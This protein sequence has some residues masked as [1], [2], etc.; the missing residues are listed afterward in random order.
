MQSKIRLL[1]LNAQ[2][3]HT[4]NESG[5]FADGSETTTSLVNKV[6]QIEQNGNIVNIFKSIIE[7]TTKDVIIPDG[8]TKIGTYAF[9]NYLNLIT[10]SISDSVV[11][12]GDWAFRICSNLESVKLSNNLKSIGVRAFASCSNL[13]DISIPATCKTIGNLAFEGCTSLTDVTLG[14]G[15][16]ANGLN[17]SYSNLYSLETLSNML[18]ALA[19]RT[20]QTAYTLILGNINLDKLTD[21]Q[22]SIATNKNWILA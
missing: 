12:I 3:A 9:Y 5:V 16:N 2:L 15:F 13:K 17:L 20:G 1:Q 19:D 6:S 4:L 14:V 21:E 18:T 8:I 10:L 7:R 22:K 11:E